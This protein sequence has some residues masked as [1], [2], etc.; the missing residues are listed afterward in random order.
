MPTI[1]IETQ[2][3]KNLVY[4]FCH[5]M[6]LQLESHTRSWNFEIRLIHLYNYVI[7]GTL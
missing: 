5:M 6:H 4:S 7:T 3:P 2:K 1:V